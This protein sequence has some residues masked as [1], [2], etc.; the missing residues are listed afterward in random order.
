[1]NLGRLLAMCGLFQH[2]L[3]LKK[4]K[5]QEGSGRSLVGE[6][7]ACPLPNGVNGIMFV[8]IVCNPGLENIFV[9][10]R[11]TILSSVDRGSKSVGCKMP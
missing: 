5:E 8:L 1:M 4:G 3:F 6:K 11:L 9:Q 7:I 2:D 10:I